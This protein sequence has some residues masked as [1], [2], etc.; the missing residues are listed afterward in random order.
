MIIEKFLRNAKSKKHINNSRKFLYE[1]QIT[2]LKKMT[3][4][5]KLD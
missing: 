2:A 5:I 4:F 1:V 3:K